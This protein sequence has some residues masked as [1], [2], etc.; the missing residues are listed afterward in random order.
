MYIY[1]YECIIIYIPAIGGQTSEELISLLSGKKEGNLSLFQ[2]C[3]L[4]APHAWPRTPLPLRTQRE[5]GLTM[6]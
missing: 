6:I 3:S 4:S 1:M 5:M 2:L